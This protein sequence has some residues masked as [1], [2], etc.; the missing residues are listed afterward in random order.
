M[1]EE[2]KNKTTQ[3][4]NSYNAANYDSLRIVIPKGQKQAVEAHVS[5]KGQSVNGYVNGLIR[6]DMGLTEDEWKGGKPEKSSD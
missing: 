1:A 2:K 6:E 4:K 5:G 3:Y